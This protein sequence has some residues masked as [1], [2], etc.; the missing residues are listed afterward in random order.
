MYVESVSM[1]DF[2]CFENAS[3]TFVYPGTTALPEGA[4][5]NVTLLIGINGAGKTS[6]LKAISLGVLAPIVENLGYRP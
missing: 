1:T 6:L 3:T 2:R 5:P 4:L